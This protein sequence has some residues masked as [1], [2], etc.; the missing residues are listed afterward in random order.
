MAENKN[1]LFESAGFWVAVASALAVVGG[2]FVSLGG[3]HV[4]QADKTLH[5]IGWVMIVGALVALVHALGLFHGHR[6][7]ERHRSE[8]PAAATATEAPVLLGGNPPGVFPSVD[9]P[10]VPVPPSA[11]PDELVDVT[12]EQLKTIRRENTALAASAKLKPYIGKWLTVTAEISELREVKANVYPPNKEPARIVATLG[13]SAW[14]YLAEATFSGAWRDRLV[15]IPLGSMVTIRGRLS[16]V[17]GYY[18]AYLHESGLIRV[19]PATSEENSG[20]ESPNS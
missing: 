5:I 1:G 13:P 4:T 6:L 18:G 19:H 7:Y 8:T 14:G 2:G 11:D 10:P 15:T 12:A 17:D 3:I 9:A 16:S 20:T